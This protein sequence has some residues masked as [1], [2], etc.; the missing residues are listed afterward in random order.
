M[1]EVCPTSLVEQEGW[2]RSDY[3]LCGA[4]GMV[5]VIATSYVEQ[6]GWFRSDLL[7]MWSRK[8]G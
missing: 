8:D 2:L 7:A 6:E 1:V 4:G 3:L 5:E